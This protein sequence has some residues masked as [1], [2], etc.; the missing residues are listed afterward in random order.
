ML[1]IVAGS[2]RIK[3]KRKT[4]LLFTFIQ[5]IVMTTFSD[6][7]NKLIDE[8][9][10]LI[11]ELVIDAGKLVKDGFSKTKSVDYKTSNYDLVTEY[12]RRCEELLIQGIKN[13]YP[14]HR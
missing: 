4:N 6:V 13:K 3:R 9:Y 2:S 7:E 11:N 1:V 12:D 10:T 8:C 5:T 14:N